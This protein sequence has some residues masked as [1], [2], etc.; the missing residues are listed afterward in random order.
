MTPSSVPPASAPPTRTSGPGGLRVL[1][2]S[3]TAQ[4]GEYSILGLARDAD[5]LAV[6]ERIRG[7]TLALFVAAT[8][9]AVLYSLE[10]YVYSRVVHLPVSLAR[11]VPLELIS[12]YLW[13]LLAPAVMWW[14]RRYPVW[15]GAAARHRA[16]HW[17]AQLGAMLLFILIHGSLL[18]LAS[19]VLGMTSASDSVRALLAQQILSWSVLDTVV[20]AML[21]AVQHAIVYYGVSR[22]RALRASQLEAHLAQAQLQVLRMQLQPHFLFNTL[23]S[24]SAL[25][26]RD[27]QRADS[28][29]AALSDLLRMSLQNI[30]AQEVPLQAELDFVQRYAEIMRMRFGDRLN[31]TLDVQSETRDARVPTLLL[32]PLVENAFRHGLGEQVGRG[33]IRVT[34]ERRGEMLHCEVADDGKGFPAGHREGVGLTSTRQ[35]LAHLYGDRHTFSIRSAAGEGARVILEIPFQPGAPQAA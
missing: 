4:T 20:F 19:R 24:I 10:R 17:V 14:A 8:A 9:V 35:R 25:M 28:M 22:D 23:H 31:V 26:H 1:P 16:A 29:I 15:G 32:Q 2:P 21:V 13:A 6:R 30:G 3:A 7:L 34:V 33:A 27:V 11:V 18:L 12:A 5:E